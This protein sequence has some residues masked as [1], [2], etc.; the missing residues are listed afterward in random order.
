MGKRNTHVEIFQPS[1]K[2]EKI[3]TWGRNK[4]SEES[5]D[6][7]EEMILGYVENVKSLRGYRV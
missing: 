6:I 7:S 2:N 3:P 5:N 1:R 4:T